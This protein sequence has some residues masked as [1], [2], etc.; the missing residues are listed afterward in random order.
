M[1]AVVENMFQNIVAFIASGFQEKMQV[2]AM[3][4]E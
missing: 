1:H 4:E 3:L 2:T